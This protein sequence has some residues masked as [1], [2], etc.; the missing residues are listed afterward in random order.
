[1]ATDLYLDLGDLL[2]KGLVCDSRRAKRL[3]Y[4]SVVAHRLLD[5]RGDGG[6]LLIDAQREL[7]RLEDFDPDS[8]RRTRSYP[9]A[10]QQLQAADP[11][12]G[13]RFAGWLAARLGADRELLGSHPSQDNI[14]A[15]VRKALMQATASGFTLSK[16]RVILLVDHGAKTDAIMAY[17]RERKDVVLAQHRVGGEEVTR[18]KLS[19][20]FE[21]LD[22]APCALAGLGDRFDL[23]A[24]LLI[25]DIGYLRSKLVIFGPAGCEFQG[26]ARDLGVSDCVRRLMRD[27][28]EH[29]LVEDE[30]AVV[31]ALEHS[32]QTIEVA[33]R[34]FPIE[35]TLD[36][37][38]RGLS[39]E[40]AQEVKRTLLS[41]YGRH[42]EPIG[43]VALIGGGA[44]LV[45]RQLASALG[46]LDLGLDTIHV[47]PKP[48]H[49]LIDGARRSERP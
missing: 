26:E 10:A 24:R 48:N 49:L 36:K 20:D 34:R 19:L 17:G 29:G 28:Q 15:L 9:R 33:G 11:V 37:A 13:A 23:P 42:P 44:P 7:T 1:M 35:A 3:R 6:E 43:T 46:D 31:R 41:H 30:L 39:E 38:R 45:G 4:P 5:E 8:Y 12:A 25:V 18:L 2:T 47:E 14:D 22:S 27:E 16:L 40:L 32:Q 21:V